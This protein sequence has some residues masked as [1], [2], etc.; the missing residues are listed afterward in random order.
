MNRDLGSFNGRKAIQ[1]ALRDSQ[2]GRSGLNVYASKSN[3]GSVHRIIRFKVHHGL[4]YGYAL[5][6]GKW[7]VISGWEER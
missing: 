3:D 7:I 6:S 1:K 4:E 2:N 5:N